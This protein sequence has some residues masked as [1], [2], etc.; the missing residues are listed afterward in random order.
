MHKGF[1]NFQSQI[2][3]V[4][5]MNRHVIVE[6]K[7]FIVWFI[8]FIVTTWSVLWWVLQIL[9]IN[10]F[11]VNIHIKGLWLNWL[12]MNALAS[13]FA[14]ATVKY[15]P[16][17]MYFIRC[18]QRSSIC[19]LNLS[20]LSIVIFSNFTSL[21]QGII[22]PVTSS[23]KGAIFLAPGTINWNLSR[24][25]F[26]ETKYIPPM[27]RWKQKQKHQLSKSFYLEKKDLL[28]RE[29]IKTTI[30]LFI[31]TEHSIVLY[32]KIWQLIFYYHFSS[33]LSLSHFFCQVCSTKFWFRER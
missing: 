28:D 15:S 24:L 9:L 18:L 11:P 7:N 14:F 10:I 17:S 21:E 12:S 29:I 5:L 19:F 13:I 25:V 16:E 6:L 1:E 22:F 8:T 3:Q 27:Q 4:S 32:S 30:S 26:I 31:E 2:V 33:P 20:S 23:L